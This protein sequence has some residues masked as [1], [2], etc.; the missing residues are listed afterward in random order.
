MAPD[1]KAIEY[2]DEDEPCYSTGHDTETMYDDAEGYDWRCRR[3]GAEGW[4]D[5]EDDLTVVAL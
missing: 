2:D 3:C 4:E 5:W 1:S